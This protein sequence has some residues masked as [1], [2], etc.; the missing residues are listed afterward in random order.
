MKEN[1]EKSAH[2]KFVTWDELVAGSRR[3]GEGQPKIQAKLNERIVFP[4]KEETY[5]E[6]AQG[7]VVAERKETEAS[8]FPMSVSDLEVILPYL[9]RKEG[10]ISGLSEENR[11][12]AARISKSQVIGST[13]HELD[14]LFSVVA[15]DSG[16]MLIGNVMPTVGD[17]ANNNKLTRYRQI[18]DGLHPNSKTFDEYKGLFMKV[19]DRRRELGGLVKGGMVPLFGELP[20]VD[21]HL[22]KQFVY[23]S[24]D[25][26]AT[27]ERL[28]QYW[29][30]QLTSNDPATWE[31]SGLSS[32]REILAIVNFDD[33]PIQL[34]G[35]IDCVMRKKN[36]RGK[37]VCWE[38]DLKTG[39]EGRSGNPL[40]DEIT[41]RQNQ[42]YFEMAA[43]FTSIQSQ[44][45]QLWIR[46]IRHGSRNVIRKQGEPFV[47]NKVTLT[48]SAHTERLHRVSIRR[49]DP[50]SGESGIEDLSIDDRQEFVAWLYWLG[51]QVLDN[52]EELRQ[53][54]KR[55]VRYNLDIARL[56]E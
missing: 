36:R 12:G 16:G 5:S 54:K 21:P 51:R 3:D 37:N 26:Y 31:F 34:R 11:R 13:L 42:V 15:Q 35:M 40:K 33:V 2:P 24:E 29:A 49:F 41:L 25:L 9:W 47:F 48:S 1:N 38:T 53:L 43:R 23:E 28:A 4:F 22:E 39:E 7:W 56:V 17:T 46:P 44:L 32:T 19:I 27:E 8:R 10:W 52:K 45:D 6:L 50:K 18:T 14:A 20:G 30:E 55:G